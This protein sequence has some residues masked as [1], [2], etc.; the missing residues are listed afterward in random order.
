MV[1]FRAIWY[2]GLFLECSLNLLRTHYG[3]TGDELEAPSRMIKPINLLINCHGILYARDKRFSIIL[4]MGWTKGIFE[5]LLSHSFPAFL[6]E[7]PQGLLPRKKGKVSLE[8]LKGELSS[9]HAHCCSKSKIP[10][11]CACVY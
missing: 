10:M 5:I 4:I 7:F 6:L 8:C 3:L 9:R 11:K 2:L 1:L